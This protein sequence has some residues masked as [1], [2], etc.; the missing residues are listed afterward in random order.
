MDIK[1]LCKIETTHLL[2]LLTTSYSRI[3]PSTHTTIRT[4]RFAQISEYFFKKYRF[5]P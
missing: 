4:G 1:I 2:C 3:S 5:Y